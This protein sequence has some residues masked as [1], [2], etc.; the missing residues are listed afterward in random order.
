MRK[1]EIERPG[2]N[3]SASGLWPMENFEPVADRIG[4]HDQVFHP[5]LVG[6]RASAAGGGNAGLVQLGG[7][8]IERGSVRYLPAEEAD[9]FAAVLADDDALLAVVIA[10]TTICLASA[11]RSRRSRSPSAPAPQPPQPPRC[12]CGHPGTAHYRHPRTCSSCRSNTKP[13]SASGGRSYVLHRHAERLSMPRPLDFLCR[14][15]LDVF[16]SPSHGVGCRE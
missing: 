5:A 6:E 1:P 10:D 13:A 16:R 12:G 9:T 3:G 2:L 14:D 15:P 8:P 11:G 4:E 7:D